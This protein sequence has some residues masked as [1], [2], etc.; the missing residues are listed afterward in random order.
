MQVDRRR[1]LIPIAGIIAV[2]VV[3]AVVVVAVIVPQRAAVDAATARLE[4]AVEAR[5]AAV[6]A[7][8]EARAALLAAGDEASALLSVVGR[9]AVADPS[10]LD[11]LAAVTVDA[12]DP[13]VPNAVPP[14]PGDAAAI[15]AV[16]ERVGAETA[17]LE[18]RA[19]SLAAE[20]DAVAG[21]SLAVVASVHAWGLNTPTP[22]HA[23]ADAAEAYTAAL[24]A[25]AEPA[26][27]ADLVALVTAFRTAFTTALAAH[28]LASRSVDA[29]SV[30]PTIING[31]LIA[32][33]TFR[34]PSSYGAG[35]TPE[36]EAAFAAMQAEAASL[37]L[38]LYISSGFRSYGSQ[39]AIYGNYVATQ[40]QA[41]ADTHSARPGHSEHQTGLTFDLNSITEAFGSTPEGLWVRD[42]A[43]RFG[44]IV[45][46]PPGKEAITGYIWEPWHLRYVG[47]PLATEL[48]TTGLTVEEYFGITS[49]YSY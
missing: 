22:P 45:R 11:A 18:E 8:E 17:A 16:V 23:P 27:D 49:V 33:K 36:T 6:A 48:V 21:A 3:A 15:D 13:P 20:R 10:T 44:F 30:Q 47:V 32:N 14:A 37:G 39:E 35:L 43:H 19:V 25:L 7:A 5:D 34:I 41:E 29:A 42:N 1:F 28:E 2:L 9:G 24:S 12:G 4:A 26:A 38:D 40:G 31:T 46:Y